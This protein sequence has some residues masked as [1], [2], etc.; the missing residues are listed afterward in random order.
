M[1]KPNLR[2]TSCILW[3]TLTILGFYSPNPVNAETYTAS[4]TSRD[5]YFQSQEPVTITIRTYAAQY[6]IDSMLWV[7]DD[8][9]NLVTANDDWYGL[10]SNL[11]FQALP[12]VQYRLR[13]GV[14]C[15]DPERWYG[16][17]YLIE[18]SMVPTNAPE[19]TTT[20]VETT[21]TTT[22]PP[23]TTTT[24][25]VSTTTSTS[26]TVVET[27][28]TTSVVVETS[29]PPTTTLPQIETTIPSTTTTLVAT[30]V[31][32]T[33]PP[34]TTSVVVPETTTTSTVP[35]IIP[36]TTTVPPVITITQDLKP[37]EALAIIL[38]ADALQN[39]TSD[40]ATKV[41][42]SLEVSELTDEQAEKL[43]ESVQ[44]APDSVRASFEEEVNVFGGKFDSYVPLGSNISVGQRKVLVAASAVLFVAPTVSVSSTSGSS[45]SPASRKK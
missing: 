14:C 35:V 8:Q 32:Q 12:G 18:P 16:N 27:T 31:P 36:S 26:T 22:E 15:G 43:I 24:V 2:V 17:T 29:L 40:E 6:G 7:Y 21:T 23:Q 42:E 37:E 20:T 25:E 9:N 11:S 45:S 30:T 10:D 1:L 5:F 19:T 4:I 3:L 39:L 28:T 38:L 41:F 34:T 44:S 13:A 33:V